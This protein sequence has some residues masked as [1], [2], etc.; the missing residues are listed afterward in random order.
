MKNYEEIAKRILERRDACL[1]QQQKRRQIIMRTMTA[2]GSVC[3]CLVI[4]AGIYMG[5]NRLPKPQIQPPVTTTTSTVTTTNTSPTDDTAT[6]QTTTAITTHPQQSTFTESTTSTTQSCTTAATLT[7]QTT[8]V[9]AESSVHTETT[10]SY[11]MPESTSTPEVTT[12][13]ISSGFIEETTASVPVTDSTAVPEGTSTT[14]TS[15]LPLHRLYDLVMVDDL[16]TF[17]VTDAEAE[18]WKIC[19]HLPRSIAINNSGFAE[20]HTIEVRSYGIIGYAPEIMIA[21]QYNDTDVYYIAR[22]IAE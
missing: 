16:A 22:Y 2:A 21:V 17:R 13:A 7:T 8:T 14:T 11:T 4:G 19:K 15:A 10:V 5:I 20:E 9:T 1:L 6:T 12:T 18:S 3:A